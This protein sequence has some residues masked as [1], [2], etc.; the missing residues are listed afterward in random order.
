MISNETYTKEG[1]QLKVTDFGSNDPETILEKSGVLSN[2]ALRGKKVE[3][4]DS[5]LPSKDR[6][7]SQLFHTSF[8]C[9][10]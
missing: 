3:V 7:Q 4:K 5:Q 8:S 9:S 1:Q 2:N 10:K 6:K